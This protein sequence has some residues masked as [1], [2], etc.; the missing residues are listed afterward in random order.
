M[1]KNQEWLSNQLNKNELLKMTGS[2][3]IALSTHIKE[4]E[5]NT[6]QEVWNHPDP[7]Q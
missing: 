6:L 7:E 2:I 3:E 1:M 4:N 5:P